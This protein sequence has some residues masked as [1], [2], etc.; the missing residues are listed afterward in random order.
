M[1]WF[2]GNLS[3]PLVGLDVNDMYKCLH[4]VLVCVANHGLLA[5]NIQTTPVMYVLERMNYVQFVD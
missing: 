1:V 5:K 4:Y 3:C 2:I